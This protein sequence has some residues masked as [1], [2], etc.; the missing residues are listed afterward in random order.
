[1]LLRS[2]ARRTLA[3]ASL[4]PAAA[5]D[6][7]SADGGRRWGVDKALRR[8]VSEHRLSG[9]GAG[10]QDASAHGPEADRI[11]ER[12]REARPKAEANLAR[13]VAELG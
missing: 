6:A 9:A 7:R 11:R 4:E 13:M 1:M 8:W 10:A 5:A 3:L 2:E 12:L